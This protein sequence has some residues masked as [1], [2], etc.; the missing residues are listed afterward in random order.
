MKKILLSCILVCAF[1]SSQAF[2]KI[3]IKPFIEGRGMKGW[4][5]DSIRICDTAT[6]V[7][8]QFGLGKGWTSSSDL[9]N[10]I[11]IPSTGKQF[12]QTGLRGVPLSPA[13]VTG[14]GKQE[15]FEF[16]FQPIDPDTKCINVTSKDFTGKEAA[17]YGVWLCPRTSVF[18]GKLSKMAALEGN[19]FSPEGYGKWKA[20]F[21]EKKVHWNNQFWNFN[22]LKSSTKSTSLELYNTES[23]KIKLEVKMQSDSG[24]TIIANK[25]PFRLIKKAL[26][27]LADNSTFNYKWSSKDSL[28]VSGFYSC[29]HPVFT[30][31][32]ALIVPD[33]LSDKPLIY[34]VQVANDGTFSVKIPFHHLSKVTFSN[35]L[36]PQSPL[37]EV[38]FFA[39][40]G[41][42]I[43]LTY[44]N[45]DEK[46]AVFGGDN[47]RLNNEFQVF[48]TLNPYFVSGKKVSDM[49]KSNPDNFNAWRTGKIEKLN[50][51][52]TDWQ[53]LYPVDSKMNTFIQF[54]L[55]YALVSDLTKSVFIAKKINDTLDFLPAVT[56]TS[57][58]NNPNALFVPEYVNVIRGV[59]GLQMMGFYVSVAQISS[60]IQKNAYPNTRETDLLHKFET[61]E[62]K[63]K[64]KD[65]FESYLSFY[66][67]NKS[68]IDSLF[69]KYELVISELRN[70]KLEESKQKYSLPKGFAYDLGLVN[71]FGNLL[72]FAGKP[73][74]ENQIMLLNHINP[75]L[76]ELLLERNKE[77][78]TNLEKTKS[79]KQAH[80]V[81][82]L[83]KP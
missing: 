33:I 24:L 38:S 5:I 60:F 39:E 48:S 50:Q 9:N 69:K 54:Y 6:I 10:Y 74:T 26:Y 75:D 47:E 79:S 1:L 72:I 80:T 8:G 71:E 58:Y 62:S 13:V 49:V 73:L 32:V 42:H 22:V 31:Q 7:Y 83:I 37:S 27:K 30:K 67:G 70:N 40:P 17:W 19:W 35:Q 18:T 16:I 23:K 68:Q 66:K 20:G 63:L 59:K 82:G 61:V 64:D 52:F 51:A 15:H 14:T 56:D 36:G 57:F 34:P 44:R 25:I 45:E 21:Y 2:D 29:A 41:N 81:T 78:E 65:A 77:V 76:R 55:K 3:I 11:E 43:I 4:L 53:S 46:N 28:I 12:K